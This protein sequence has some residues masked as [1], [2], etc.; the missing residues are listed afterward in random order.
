MI[1]DITAEREAETA[2]DSEARHRALVE[3]VPAVVYEMGPD[4]ERRTLFVSP[5]VE[6]LLGYSRQEWLDQPDIWMELLH[7]DDREI[8]LAAHDLPQRDRRAVDAGVPADRERRPG[9]VGARPGRARARRRGPPRTWQGV[10][11]DITAQKEAEELLRSSR[12]TTSSS[13]CSPAPRSSR[14]RTR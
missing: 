12:T 5:H 8:E 1:H 7:P 2:L 13:G 3:Q 4:D 6:E 10:M 14:R 11:L 9:R